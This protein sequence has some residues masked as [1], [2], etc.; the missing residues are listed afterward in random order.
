M[1]MARAVREV[2]AA[3]REDAIVVTGAGLPQGMVKQRWVTRSPRTHL[4]SGGFSTMGFELPAAIG[5][6]LARPEAQVLSVSGDGS[7]LQSMQELQTAVLAGTPVCQVVLDNSGW[8]SIKGG[9]ETFF[10]RT[11]WTDFL[12]PDGSTYSP[13]FAAIGRAF[14]IHSE[15]VRDP[16]EVAPAIR[17]ALASGGP[18]LVHVTVDRDLATAGPEK[19]G[20]WDAPSPEYE[21]ERHA[22]WRAGV[23]ENQAR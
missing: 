19:T 9:Q 5:A 22:A 4:T 1:T 11:A 16:D 8:I 15:G 12:T 3:T 6:Q 2:Q 18:S 13:D 20:W 21:P 10:G 14:G 17:R 7:F 23:A